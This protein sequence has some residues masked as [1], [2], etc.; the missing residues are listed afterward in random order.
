[1]REIDS[2]GKRVEELLNHGKGKLDVHF[3]NKALEF[4]TRL[5]SDVNVGKIVALAQPTNIIKCIEFAQTREKRHALAMFLLI[6]AIASGDQEAV[7]CLLLKPIKYINCS[8]DVLPLTCC[9]SLSVTI[10]TN[11]PIEIARRFNQ[12]HLMY[13][14]L[15][16]TNVYPKEG[17]VYWIGLQLRELSPSLIKGINWVK[18]LRLSRNKLTTLPNVIGKYLKQVPA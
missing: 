15:M 12:P 18:H 2:G 8:E 4:A 9:S 3:R 14:V 17:Y 11:V 1:M 10:S 6:E 7:N 16:K 5:D 13:E